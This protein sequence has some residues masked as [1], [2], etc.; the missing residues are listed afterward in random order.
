MRSQ[1]DDAGR[2]GAG[3][4]GVSGSCARAGGAGGFAA[5]RTGGGGVAG[6]GGSVRTGSGGGAASGVSSERNSPSLRSLRANACDW[7]A[8]H[9]NTGS[10]FFDRD[11]RA[12]LP[13]NGQRARPM[14]S[15]ATGSGRVKAGD[16]VLGR[17]QLGAQLVDFGGCEHHEFGA[18]FGEPDHR[19]R[20][21]A[22]VGVAD[23]G[24]G[25][26][27]DDGGGAG[28]VGGGVHDSSKW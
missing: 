15:A 12:P 2:F 20:N 24:G 23:G 19:A 6:A 17:V 11:S 9:V 7:Q 21:E 10:L 14:D 4:V 5:V 13:Q 25:F 27:R 16:F 3:G 22:R 28:G 18:Q 8:L 1:T 26:G